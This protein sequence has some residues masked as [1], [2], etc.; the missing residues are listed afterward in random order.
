LRQSLDRNYAAL[1][2]RQ[3]DPLA[4]YLLMNLSRLL[5]FPAMQREADFIQRLSFR[6]M[7]PEPLALGQ[8]A[9]DCA[10]RESASPPGIRDRAPGASAR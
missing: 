3:I 4:P 7:V 1:G 2:I 6:G 5:A 10:G 8:R 9:I